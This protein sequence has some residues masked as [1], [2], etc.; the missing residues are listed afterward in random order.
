MKISKWNLRE[1]FQN[2]NLL[3]SFFE[4]ESSLRSFL[5]TKIENENPFLKMKIYRYKLKNAEYRLRNRENWKI[6]IYLDSC[7]GV[8]L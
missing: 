3:C 6:K 2:E 5:G 4:N 8:M 7:S 1:N